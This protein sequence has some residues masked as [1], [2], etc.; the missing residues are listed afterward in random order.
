MKIAVISSTVFPSPPS[1]YAG[2]EMVAWQQAS[3]LAAL[4]HQVTLFAPDGSTCPGGQVFGFGPPGRI[5][6]V[7]AYGKYWQYLPQFDAVIDNSWQKWAYSLKAEGRLNA[8][9]LGVMHAPVDTMLSSPPPVPKPCVV[10]ISDDQKAHYEA[11]FGGQARR[12]YNGID[13][14]YYKPLGLPRSGRFLFLGRFSSVK[15]PDLAI[16]ACL[17]AGVGLDLVGDTKL[18]GEPELFEKCKRLCDGE[19]IRMVGPASRGEC[20]WWF[21]QAH[22]LVHPVKNFREPFGLAPVEAQACG[23]PVI[24]WDNGAMKET[25][26]HGRT[27]WLVTSVDDLVN[28]IK[29]TA[30]EFRAY[31]GGKENL[32]GN[33][34]EWA[35]QFSV[36][37]HAKRYDE[38]CQEAI[39]GG[40]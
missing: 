39:R 20:V 15:S 3:G 35:G 12:A 22:A 34:R 29:S 21:S 37:N 6:E 17:A 38:L 18:T 13:L 23:C 27:G 30:G 31:P 5:S 10:C 16:E 32:R 8:P 40:W 11:L 26:E 7:D 33:C 9:V 24:A 19:Q 14:E 36:Q 1:G 28:R 2:L 25:V 4:G